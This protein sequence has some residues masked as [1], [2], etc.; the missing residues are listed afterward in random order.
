MT[1]E[2]IKL[3][4]SVTR[5]AHSRKPRRSK[6]GTPDERAAM[7]KPAAPIVRP[8]GWTNG[9]NPLR[10]KVIRRSRAATIVGKV[11]YRRHNFDAAGLQNSICQQWLDELRDSIA[12]ARS[13]IGDFEKAFATL[14]MGDSAVAGPVE[15]PSETSDFPVNLPVRDL[16]QPVLNLATEHDQ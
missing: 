14:M 16:G 13:M 9:H 11:V 6:N 5:G 1:A 15:R 8:H 10:D 3:P 4:Y 2:I 7:L 12:D